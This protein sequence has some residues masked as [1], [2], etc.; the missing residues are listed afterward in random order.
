MPCG[1]SLR[2]RCVGPGA[3][4][5][6]TLWDGI[7]ILSK[8]LLLYAL[9]WG[10]LAFSASG[11]ASWIQSYC[12]PPRSRRG[13]PFVCY[14]P[15]MERYQ[16]LPGCPRIP[17]THRC[18]SPL[19]CFVTKPTFLHFCPGKS[20][21]TRRGKPPDPKGYSFPVVRP[22]RGVGRLLF[23]TF[24][25]WKGTKDCRGGPT[26]CFFPLLR[27]VTE[28]TFL[29]FCPGKS[30]KTRR[31]KPPDPPLRRTRMG[32][33]APHAP[34]RVWRLRVVPPGK[35]PSA[36]AAKNMGKQPVWRH[37]SPAGIPSGY[38]PREAV[39]GDRL[40]AAGLQPAIES[41][42]P[43]GKEAPTTRRGGQMA[44]LC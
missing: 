21:K 4:P 41:A 19:L 12:C 16:R 24:Q 43:G 20:G 29:H 5:F 35:K 11:G 30:G 6:F 10:P 1:R 18:F 37:L 38:P 7:L 39:L 31:G 27:F 34:D 17:L 2:Y 26:G 32:L 36:N 15:A 25:Q 33:V 44:I 13:P 28:P 14:F 3:K 40:G 22:G 8:V 9:G 42:A 23:V